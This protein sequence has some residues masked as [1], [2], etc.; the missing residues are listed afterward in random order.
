MPTQ[1][2]GTPNFMAP[3]MFRQHNSYA[4]QSSSTQQKKKE[5]FG[6]DMWSMGVIMYQFMYGT[7]PF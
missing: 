7:L 3:E 4:N 1:N 5:L 2:I 6:A